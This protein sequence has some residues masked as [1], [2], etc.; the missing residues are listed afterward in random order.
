MLRRDPGIDR[1]AALTARAFQAVF[2]LLFRLQYSSPDVQ[3]AT[4]DI[5][6]PARLTIPTRHGPIPA[7][8][9]KPTHGDVAAAV[10]AR[11]RAPVH[12]ITHGGGFI[13]RMP[14]QEDNVARYIASELG[15]YVL[16]PD[17]DTAPTVRHPVSE[18]QAFDAFVWAHENAERQEWDADRMSIGG[19][20]AGTQV[21][22]GVVEQAIEA[23]GPLPVAVSSEFGV[24][25]LA[26]PDEQRTS[27]K[28]RPVVSP[29]LIRLIRATYFAG[30][31]LADPLVS[32]YY[33][34]RVGEFPPTLILTGEFDVLRREMHE[35][36]DKMADDGARVTYHEFAGVDHG[37]T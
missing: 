15:A 9:Y 23:G 31:D 19:A 36:A 11:R 4:K 6:E 37:F 20:S 26:R 21:A 30:V 29:G 13:I 3:F 5:G 10:S 24:C 14:Q 12:V 17:F 8:L 32:P 27:A 18:Q 35:F 33:Y 28:K 22:F 34:T 25:D 2:P 16:L 7:L 1:R